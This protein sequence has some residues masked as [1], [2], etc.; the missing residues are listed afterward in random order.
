MHM[1][2]IIV[3]MHRIMHIHVIMQTFVMMHIDAYSYDYDA[4]DCAY[5]CCS[6]SDC[7]DAY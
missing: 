6:A 2:I 4:Y 3:M 1:F 5:Y 7:H